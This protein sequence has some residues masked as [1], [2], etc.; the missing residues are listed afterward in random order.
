MKSPVQTAHW[1]KGDAECFKGE[2][3][4]VKEEM[5]TVLKS[6]YRLF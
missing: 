3:Q 5:Q 2:L 4:T 6:D 1:F